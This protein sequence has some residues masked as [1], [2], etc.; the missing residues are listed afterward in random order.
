MPDLGTPALCVV[1]HCVTQVYYLVVQMYYY[2]YA[3][4]SLLNLFHFV[5]VVSESITLHNIMPDTYE[6]VL[7]KYI[8]LLNLFKNICVFINIVSDRFFSLAIIILF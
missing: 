5:L 2:F 1:Q 8:Y 6:Y 7:N 3:Y 4:E